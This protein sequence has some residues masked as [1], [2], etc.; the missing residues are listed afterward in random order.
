M[1]RP[2]SF[3]F[4]FRAQPGLWVVLPC[5]DIQAQMELGDCLVCVLVLIAGLSRN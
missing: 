1:M 5:P 2:Y 3:C 4:D